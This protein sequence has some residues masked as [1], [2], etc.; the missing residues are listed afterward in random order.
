[1]YVC[2]IRFRQMWF[3]H[4]SLRKRTPTADTYTP[5]KRAIKERAVK[6]AKG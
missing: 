2:K 3:L 4:T 6:S 1:M 5:I